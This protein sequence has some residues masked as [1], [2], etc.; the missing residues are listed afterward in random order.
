V[1]RKPY[2]DRLDISLVFVV[3]EGDVKTLWFNLKS[4]THRTI[5]LSRYANAYN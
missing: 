1:V 4:D 5:D 2:D 3:P